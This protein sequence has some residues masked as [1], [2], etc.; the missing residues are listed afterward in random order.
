M[1][2]V[3]NLIGTAF[4]AYFKKENLVY[5]LKIVLAQILIVLGF[6]VPIVFI[7]SIF[8]G[9]ASFF[10]GSLEESLLPFLAILS[11]IT[12]LFMVGVAIVS[13][14]LSATVLVAVYQV[15]HQKLIGVGETLSAGWKLVWKYLG[16]SIISG[17]VVFLGLVFFVIPGIVFGIWF[18]F[19]LYLM[20]D[21]KTSVID[22][23]EQSKALVSGFFWSVL[24]RYIVFGILAFAIVL[25]LS[26]I[27]FI[28]SLLSAF[29]APFYTLLGYL[30]YEDLKKAK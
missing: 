10:I 19:S 26:F 5:F 11:P 15:A 14:W 3:F 2:P 1:T 4:E 12:V 6:V 29:F 18:S 17:M 9:F 22:S 24:G 13:S 21:K 8:G 16:V 25:F 30:L 27:P 20:I 7:I 28:G 23:L